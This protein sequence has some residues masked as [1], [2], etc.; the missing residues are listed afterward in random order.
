MAQGHHDQAQRELATSRDRQPKK[1]E[2]W[3]ALSELADRGGPREGALKILDDAACQLGDRI[4]L[5][6]ARA[7]HWARAGGARASQALARAEQGAGKFPAIDQE[8]LLRGLAEAYLRIGEISQAS[9]L[10]E[11]LVQKRPFDLGLHFARFSLA[12]EVGDQGGMERS[13]QGL[14]SLENDLEAADPKAGAFWRCAQ[15]RYLTWSAR[16][17]KNGSI[18]KQT[19]DEARRYLAEAGGRR[20]AWNLIPLAEAEINDLL[21]NP[22]AAIKAYS[23][24]IELGMQEP[25]VIRRAV[26]LLFDRRRYD[27]AFELIKKLQDQGF[28]SHDSQLQRLAAEVSLQVN[29]RTRALDLRGRQSRR[30][31]RT[32]AITS[33]WARSCWRRESR[34]RRSQNSAAPPRSRARH[35]MPGSH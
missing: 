12:L 3:I 8:R 5:R 24:S 4:E 20:P 27:Q 22:D 31:R 23:R 35:P 21:G 14:R 7:N 30:T 28:P 34:A 10:L 6:L 26:Q 11:T 17:A 33:G 2:L 13:L 32:I 18:R 9:R 15:A 1:V 25:P 29:E 16:R 19:L